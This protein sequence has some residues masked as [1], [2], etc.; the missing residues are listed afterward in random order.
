M[1]QDKSGFN[2]VGL[3]AAALCGVI[4]H[5]GLLAFNVAMARVRP[6]PLALPARLPIL[7]RS[8][9]EANCVLT[10]VCAVLVGFVSHR[11]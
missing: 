2:L 5:L 4:I 10:R 9:P 6:S 7:M 11:V 8:M 3:A 1:A